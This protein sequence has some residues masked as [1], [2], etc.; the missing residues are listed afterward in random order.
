MTTVRC[1]RRGA[2]R[3]RPAAA[4]YRPA[5]ARYRPAAARYRPA[6]A[7][8][9]AF[10]GRLPGVLAMWSIGPPRSNP[11]LCLQAASVVVRGLRECRAWCFWPGETGF[12][13]FMIPG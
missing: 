13:V 12:S 9:A 3:Y 11:S 5:A 4:R 7:R 2:A 10:A 1:V 6:A 8:Y